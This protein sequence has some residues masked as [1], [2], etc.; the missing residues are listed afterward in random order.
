MVLLICAIIGLGISFVLPVLPVHVLW[1]LLFL[2]LILGLI[3]IIQIRSI[4]SYKSLFC[5]LIVICL[6]THCFLLTQSV[7]RRKLYDK[8][9]ITNSNHQECEVNG[10]TD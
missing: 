7:L 10:N 9:S 4:K 3:G 8:R 2:Y 1:P 6:S 5:L